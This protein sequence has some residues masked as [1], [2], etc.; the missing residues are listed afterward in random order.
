MNCLYIYMF[1]QY[2]FPFR[3]YLT[4][5]LMYYFVSVEDTEEEVMEEEVPKKKRKSRVPTGLKS[6]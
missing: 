5:A 2:E 6:T 3:N 1:H 4:E